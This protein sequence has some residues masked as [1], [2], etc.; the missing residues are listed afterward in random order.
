MYAK[1]RF[2]CFRP[3]ILSLSN[4]SPK[5]EIVSLTC[6]LVRRLIRILII[7]CQ[8]SLFSVLDWKY[9]SVLN[10]RGGTLI[11][12]SNFFF[13]LKFG[14]KTN[15]NLNNSIAMLTFYV[16]DWKYL[17]WA[18]LVQKINMVSLSWDLV[19]ILIRICRIQWQCSLF[20]FEIGNTFFG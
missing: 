1:L 3:K 5:I 11:N 16:L 8:C 2:F 7:Q 10:K 4:F 12:F 13:F 6:N 14:T 15:F 17:F 19:P 20:L 9:S 18:N